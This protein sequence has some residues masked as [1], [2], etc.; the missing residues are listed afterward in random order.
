MAWKRSQH[1][2]LAL[3]ISALAILILQDYKANDGW[4]WSPR[5]T[6]RQAPR[7]FKM[8]SPRVGRGSCPMGS[9]CGT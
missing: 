6:E 3:P 9:L 4:N 8:P 7:T 2:T 5:A 1:D